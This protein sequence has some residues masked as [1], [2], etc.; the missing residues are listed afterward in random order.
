MR[1]IW[2]KENSWGFSVQRITEMWQR[3]GRS[4]RRHLTVARIAN[5]ALLGAELALRRTRMHARPLV[6][7]IEPT[8]FCNFQCPGCR[9][10]SGEDTSPRGQI[11]WDDYVQI[12]D[13]T[14]RTSFKLILYMW[15]EPF[16]N[17]NIFR[18]IE[19]AGTKNLGVQISTNLNV[20]RPEIDAPKLVASGLEHM[21]VA[22]DGITQEVYEKYRIGGKVDK[23]IRGVEAVMAERKRQKR[24][25]PFVELQYIVF[26]HNR[27]QM[28]EVQELAGRL[29]V[30]R[31]TFIVSKTREEAMV[32]DGQAV[33]PEKCHALWTMAC[34]NWDGSFSPCCDSVDD[35]FGN[36]LREDFGALWNSPKMQASRSLMTNHPRTGVAS[37]CSRCRIYRGYV[38]FLPGAEE[39][40]SIAANASH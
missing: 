28:Q 21:I 30:D 8:N 37:K 4:V 29:G 25:F 24:K 14:A 13:K 26:P 1:T 22:L 16:I 6:T 39:L 35:S 23:V 5:A 19:Y 20:F 15:G 12:V 3:H 18:M 2:L 7:K 31:L 33:K 40:V 34:F 27:H 32:E 17:K 11:A 9:T 38:T 36:G 10:G